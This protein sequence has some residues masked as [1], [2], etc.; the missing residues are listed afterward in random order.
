MEATRPRALYR[1]AGAGAWLDVA[2][3]VAGFLLLLRLAPSQSMIPVDATGVIGNLALL[4]LPFALARRDARNGG[5]TL[6]LGIVALVL[7]ICTVIAD[8]VGIA[9]DPV[10]TILD[11]A[12][13]ALFGAWLL[14]VN[15]SGALPGALIRLG[16]WGGALL[17]VFA[18]LLV[19]TAVTMT[20]QPEVAEAPQAGSS[21]TADSGASP[22]LAIILL[23]LANTPE[24]VWEVFVGGYLLALADLPDRP[25]ESLHR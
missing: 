2:C 7:T 5:A 9:P 23:A 22:P 11:A 12:A 3:G 1:L 8:A 18:L 4:P 25:L 6:A 24:L 16:R 13:T 10:R 17:L 14:L 15:R 21:L 20:F 19:G